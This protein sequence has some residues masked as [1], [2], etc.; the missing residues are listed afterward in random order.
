M[1]YVALLRGINVGGNNA[2]KM[3]VLKEVFEAS[4]FTKVRTY[5]NSGNVIFS[6]DEEDTKKLTEEIE[7]LLTKKFHYQARTVVKSYIQIKQIV[8]STPQ[9]WKKRTDIRCYIAF[10]SDFLSEKDAVKEITLREGVDTLETGPGVLYMTSVI[11]ELT[12]SNF[13]KLA[14]KKIYQ[15]MTIRNYNTSQKILE[16][17]DND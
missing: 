10:L 9:E 12:K 3:S 15:E 16:L 8:A 6:S 11:N 7:A 17:M 5:I 14:S 4:G 13:N 2:T 1:E